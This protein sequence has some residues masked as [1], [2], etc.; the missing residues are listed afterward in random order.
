MSFRL[1]LLIQE[2]HRL[3]ARYFEPFAAAHV[4]ASHQVVAANHVGPGLSELG[5]IALVG[6]GGS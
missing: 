5:A 2:G 1:D 3:D 6:A 4:L